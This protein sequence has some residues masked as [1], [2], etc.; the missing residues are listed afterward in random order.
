MWSAMC[1]SSGEK[2]TFYLRTTRN[3]QEYPTEEYDA[4]CQTLAF[5]ATP[6]EEA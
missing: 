4:E 2:N 1:F 5:G 3:D 6:K